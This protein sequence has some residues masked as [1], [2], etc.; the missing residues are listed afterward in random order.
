MPYERNSISTS[1]PSP[2]VSNL[3]LF[4]LCLISACARFYIRIHLQKSFSIDDGILLFG[5]ACLICAMG[6]LFKLADTM[7][8]IGASEAGAP[9]LIFPPDF[10]ERSFEFEKLAAVV[11]IL[12]WCSI[13]SVKFSYLFLFK[14]L[15]SRIRPLV[16]YWWFV[17]VF[18]AI[19]SAYGA[20]VYIAACPVFYNI[21]ACKNVFWNGRKCSGILG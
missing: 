4:V 13:V 10:I 9:G 12:T 21:N 17:A 7:F 1:N 15:L 5:I 18:N 3:V 19:I 6:V 14:K 11:G 16:I 8:L 20:T 2:K